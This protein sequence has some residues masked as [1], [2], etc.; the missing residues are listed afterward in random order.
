MN[1]IFLQ[2]QGNEKSGTVLYFCDFGLLEISN[3]T[4][5]KW[6]YLQNRNRLTDFKNKLMA[7]KGEGGRINEEFGINRYSL[8]DTK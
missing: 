8:L 7:T 6:I 3:K 5:Y 1:D 4:W 2:K